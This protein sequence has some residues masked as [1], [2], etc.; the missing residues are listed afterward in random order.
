M[1]WVTVAAMTVGILGLSAC[2]GSEKKTAEPAASS[3]A[4]TRPTLGDT[5]EAGLFLTAVFDDPSVGSDAQQKWLNV[6]VTV[7]NDFGGEQGGG[8]PQEF[9]FA[10]I[11]AGNYTAG[12]YVVGVDRPSPAFPFA[13]PPAVPNGETSGYVSLGLPKADDGQVVEACDHAE[14]GIA[15]LEPAGA[16]TLVLPDDLTEQLRPAR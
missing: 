16:T 6:R 10:L 13:D 14:M 4:D 15:I 7:T 12:S 2:A 11:C 8:P 9:D 1:R 3:S 5:I